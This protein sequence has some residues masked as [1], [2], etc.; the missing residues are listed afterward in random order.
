M[1]QHEVEHS[2]WYSITQ[3][4]PELTPTDLDYYAATTIV[5]CS[6]WC[7]EWDDITELEDTLISE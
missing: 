7:D 4:L 5:D 6:K 1:N 3:D 2:P